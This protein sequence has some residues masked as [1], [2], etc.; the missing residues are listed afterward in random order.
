MSRSPD[1]GQIPFRCSSAIFEPLP[2]HASIGNTEKD[3]NVLSDASVASYGNSGEFSAAAVVHAED[4]CVPYRFA[5]SPDVDSK[6]DTS[7]NAS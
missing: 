4:L 2:S 3:S 7:G 6:T 5:A 1:T